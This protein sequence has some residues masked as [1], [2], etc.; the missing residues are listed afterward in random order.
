MLKQFCLALAILVG[1]QSLSHAADDPVDPASRVMLEQVAKAYGGLKFMSLKGAVALRVVEDDQPTT[2]SSA[3][4]GAY[5]APN[6]LRHQV[7]NQ[8]LVGITGDTAFGYSQEANAFIQENI[9]PEKTALA[10]LP[11][12]IRGILT[13]QNM[14]LVMAICADPVA[15]LIGLTKKIEKL[16]DEPIDGQPH[17]AVRLTL[18]DKDQT[19]TL[20]V[21]S[22]TNLIRRQVLDMLPMV[23]SSGRQDLSAVTFTVDFATVDTKTEPKPDLFAWAAPAGAKDLLAA[24]AEAQARAEV[25]QGDAMKLVGKPAPDLALPD[26]QGKVV[27]L[28]DLKGSVVVLD[29]WATWCGPCVAS[30]P[31]LD[32]LYQEKSPQ[33]LKMFALNQQEEQP[34]VQKFINDKNLSIPVLLDAKGD[35]AKSYKVTGIPQTVLIGKD[36]LVKKVVIGFNPKGDGMAEAVDAELKV[37]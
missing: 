22:K 34:L 1:L 7:D 25:G 20:F 4:T 21:D 31:H 27:K 16:P 30:L 26:M 3:L 24:R 11:E 15:E 9:P 6:R 17:S 13:T 12:S 33:G 10:S 32:K 14:P 37:R 36:G 35:V 2:H 29:F 5:L 19:L 23:K 18:K 8:P 28:S